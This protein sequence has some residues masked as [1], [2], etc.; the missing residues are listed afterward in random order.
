[1]LEAK[2]KKYGVGEWPLTKK[3]E[4]IY[5]VRRVLNTNP[6]DPFLTN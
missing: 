3:A 6:G 4:D 1:V 2:G 5:S